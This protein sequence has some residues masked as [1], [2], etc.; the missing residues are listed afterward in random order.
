LEPLA[1]AIFHYPQPQPRC[2]QQ[3]GS[4]NGAHSY[5]VVIPTHS[6]QSKRNTSNTGAPATRM[7]N[8]SEDLLGVGASKL[9]GWRGG[10]LGVILDGRSNGSSKAGPGIIATRGDLAG[11]EDATGSVGTV[12]TGLDVVPPPF[13]V[14]GILGDFW[15]TGTSTAAA[16]ESIF[17]CDF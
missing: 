15:A 7:R 17:L 8:T 4:T 2:K 3:L 11:V 6:A 10:F 12:A 9:D 16:G 14:F 1:L 5:P 13:E